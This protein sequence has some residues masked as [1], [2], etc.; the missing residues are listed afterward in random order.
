M[1][2]ASSCRQMTDIG[3]GLRNGRRGDLFVA[4]R[5][6]GPWRWLCLSNT[7]SYQSVSFYRQVY[8]LQDIS[9]L[10]NALFESD[11]DYNL[12]NR[13]YTSAFAWTCP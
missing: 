2:F 12:V 5:P 8:T 4:G 6:L 13:R 1:G 9:E 7:D 10:G 11:E 3:R